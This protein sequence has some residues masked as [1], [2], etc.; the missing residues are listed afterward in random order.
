MKK[1]LLSSVAVL[2]LASVGHADELSD[3]KE[4][5]KLLREQMSK[6]LS[7]LEKRQKA[8]ETK[9]P[10]AINPVDAM[11]AD[12]PYKAAV[13]AKPPRARPAMAVL[14]PTRWRT[15]AGAVV[16]EGIFCIDST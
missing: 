6:R 9:T 14:R 12:L 2:A 5:A 7:D 15:P 16:W 10:V 13:K 4:Q 11:A 3:V 1:I 8:L